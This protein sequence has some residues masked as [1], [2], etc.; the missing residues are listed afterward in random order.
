MPLPVSARMSERIRNDGRRLVFGWRL[1]V[2]ACYFDARR[3]SRR[4]STNALRFQ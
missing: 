4:L 1:S 2:A 3:N